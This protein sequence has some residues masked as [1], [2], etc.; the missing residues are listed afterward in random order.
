MRQPYPLILAS[1]SLTRQKLLEKLGLSFQVV[2]SKIREEIHQ[3]WSSPEELVKILALKKAE[4]VA[5]KVNRGIILGVDTVVICNNKIYGKPKNLK[6]AKEF[7]GEL[8]GKEQEIYT[9]IAL[10][11]EPG[12]RKLTS[13]V[14]TKVKMALLTK[15]EIKQLARQHLNKAGAYGISGK[16]DSLLKKISGEYENILGLPVRELKNLLCRFGFNF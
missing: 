2:S 7:L 10:L 6:E 11:K 4:K 1:G 9:G 15:R 14:K 8:A 5:E 16:K 12:K 13:V 3:R